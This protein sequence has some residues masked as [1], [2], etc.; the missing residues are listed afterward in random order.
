MFVLCTKCFCRSIS[1]DVL[2]MWL[3]L[4][5]D[6]KPSREEPIPE[7]L[8]SKELTPGSTSYEPMTPY[9]RTICMC[10]LLSTIIQRKEGDV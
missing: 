3:A 10:V 2:A 7:A 4:G 1:P 8:G 5:L 9:I 6:R